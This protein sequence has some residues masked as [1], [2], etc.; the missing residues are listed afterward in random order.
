MAA[1]FVVLQDLGRHVQRRTCTWDV[2]SLQF[3]VVQ[4]LVR[5]SKIP[6]FDSF[7]G[8][9]NVRGLQ[10]PVDDAVPE[11]GLETLDDIQHVGDCLGLNEPPL[12]LDLALK[13]PIFA[14]LGH[15]ENRVL[16]VEL[17][18]YLDNVGLLSQLPVDVQLVSKHLFFLWLVQDCFVNSLN[19]HFLIC[20]T[21]KFTCNLV[22]PLVD[23]R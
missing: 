12:L 19:C 9:E 1:V 16:F 7:F 17:R 5:K 11:Q 22:Y 21:F 6:D 14:K 10:V 15:D 23:Y 8:N 20:I 2:L 3:G 13:V 18:L 4:V